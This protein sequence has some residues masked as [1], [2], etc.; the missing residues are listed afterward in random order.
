M[1]IS[2][3][4]ST[5]RYAGNGST[6]AFAITWAYLAKA[7]IVATLRASDGT[8]SVQV[9]DT[10][11][12]LTDVG[13][14]GTL[15]MTT[16]PASGET[17]VITSEPPNTQ[18]TDIP[19]GGSFPARAV[20][21]G[22]DV[23]SQVSQKIESLFDRSLRVPK[24]DTRIGSQLEIPNEVA[25]ASKFLAFDASGYPIT[26]TGPT[27]DSSIPVST[28]METV[29]DD[30][31]AAAARTTLGIIPTIPSIPTGT[32]MLFFQAAA[33]TGW[34]QIAANDDKA[35]RVVS[36]TGGGTGGTVAFET[37]FASQAVTAVGGVTG[38]HTLTAA[39]M[40]AHTH[41]VGN[42]QQLWVAQGAPQAAYSGM[43]TGIVNHLFP[44][45]STGGGTG[46]THTFTGT[47]INLDAAYINVI[48][49]SKD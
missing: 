23:A 32:V 39:Q 24:T 4:A 18:T 43:N 44:T 28:F 20:E 30:P 6:T 45:Q 14:S 48:Y 19:L 21:D 29:L 31:T 41:N 42:Q 49:C 38:S 5:L 26:S 34:T 37:A 22:L 17:L 8:E 9:L 11:Y 36:G 33:P 7:H 25:R 27:G 47:A 16:A 12:T 2:T 46:H 35:I 13:A 15:T 3:P 1:T 10:D 40:P